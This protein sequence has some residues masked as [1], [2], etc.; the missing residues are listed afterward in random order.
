MPIKINLLAEA[1][2]QEE[3]RRKDPVKHLILAG[4]V[5]IVVVLVWS[6]SL[7]V[8]TFVAKG[9]VTRLEAQTTAREASYKEILENQKSAVDGKRKLMA[10][11]RLA[12]ERFLT[13]NLLNALQKDTLSNIQLARLKVDQNYV[14][15]PEV[16]PTKQSRV[17]AKP[18]T[19]KENITILLSAK[20][21]SPLPGDGVS[22]FQNLLS[23]DPYFQN[24]LDK[25][26]FHLTTLS[27]AQVD[28]DGKSY[29]QMGLEGRLPEKIR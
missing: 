3:A 7:L 12:R 21:K 27:P 9:E 18:A 5:L 19:I 23:Q 24:I 20:D 17:Q 29:L 13:G 1:Q 15:V 10:L 16:K 2:A 26:C 28:T 22:K 25:N 11:D 4:A 14:L 8:E 6:S